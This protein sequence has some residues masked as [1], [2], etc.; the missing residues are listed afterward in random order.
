MKKTPIQ[1]PDRGPAVRAVRD[2]QVGLADRVDRVVRDD[3]VVR[4]GRDDRVDRV[5]RRTF[6]KLEIEDGERRSGIK[7]WLKRLFR[8]KDRPR[9][10]GPDG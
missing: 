4:A 3:R 9:P 6:E 8:R 5:V 10:S 1:F 2:D 7:E